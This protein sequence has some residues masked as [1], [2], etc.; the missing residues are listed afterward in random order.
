MNDWD[1][2]TFLF[3]LGLPIAGGCLWI[4]ASWI[5]A[6]TGGWSAIAKEFQTCHRPR[7]GA[8]SWCSL[9]FEPCTAY[10]NCIQVTLCNEGIFMIPVMLFRFGHP[11]VLIPWS[12]VGAMQPRDWPFPGII[13]PIDLP[14][15][16]LELLLPLSAKP[17]IEGRAG[18]CSPEIEAS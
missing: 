10:R 18:D 6:Q 16:P 8:F 15:Q 12:H 14:D 13:L 1:P 5:M 7:G 3:V 17:W 9:H 11:A 2:L 4:L